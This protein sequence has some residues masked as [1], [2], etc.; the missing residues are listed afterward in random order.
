M[1][2]KNSYI[3]V[4]TLNDP[5]SPTGVTTVLARSGTNTDLRPETARSWTLGTDLEF[6]SVPGLSVSL[7]YFNVNYSSR[8]DNVQ[9]GRDVLSLP[10]LNWLVNRNVTAA[11]LNDVCTNSIYRGPGTCET[12]SATA[13][14]DNRLRNIALLRTDG[15]DLIGR[16]SFENPAGKFDLGLNGTYLFA[17]S[18]ANTPSS[19]VVNIVSTQSNPINIKARGSASWIRRGFGVSTF[20]NFQNHYQDTLSVPNRGVSP[21]TT[22]DL[23]LSYET[24]G[25]TLGWLEHTQFALNAQNLFNVDPPFLNNSAAG[26]GYDQENADLYGRMVSFEVRKR[27]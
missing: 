27:W 21:W 15:I 4:A 7:T 20:I 5:S 9:F 14:I 17:Y 6:K 1:V 19:P 10:T 16:Y 11:E 2:A 24:T 23:Q 25:D 8:I 22:I 26:V 13:I 18:Q 3:D 12:T